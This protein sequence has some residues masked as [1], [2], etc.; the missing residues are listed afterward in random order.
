MEYSE[1]ISEIEELVK[2]QSGGNYSKWMIGRTNDS[3]N[4]KTK[5]GE[6]NSWGGIGM[7]IPNMM[8]IK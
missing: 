6:P 7:P 5:R 4:S 1:I 3:E 8:Q 2:S